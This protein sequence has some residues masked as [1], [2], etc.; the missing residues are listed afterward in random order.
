[1]VPGKGSVGA[2]ECEFRRPRVARS[3]KGRGFRESLVEVN[4]E[5]ADP[6]VECPKGTIWWFPVCAE[7]TIHIHAIRDKCWIVAVVS[8]DNNN[9]LISLSDTNNIEFQN[10]GRIRI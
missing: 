9:S 6:V 1:M 5:I 7:D 3:Q 8:Q 10:R 2:K 4:G